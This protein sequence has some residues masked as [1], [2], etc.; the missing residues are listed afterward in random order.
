MWIWI[1]VGHGKKQIFGR[2]FAWEK[3]R[4]RNNHVCSGK[5]SGGEGEGEGE[6]EG[7]GRTSMARSRFL[8]ASAELAR[9]V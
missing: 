5:G 6:G 8:K 7:W 2:A 4:A 9:A 1:S 3:I